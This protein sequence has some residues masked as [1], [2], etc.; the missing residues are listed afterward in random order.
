ML[1]PGDGGDGSGA[2]QLKILKKKR[3]HVKAQC[4]R[5]SSYLDGLDRQGIAIAELRQRLQKFNETWDSFNVTQSAI[6]DI[7]DDPENAEGHERERNLFEEKYFH[8]AS[9]LETLIDRKLAAQTP[10]LNQIPRE[11]REGTPATYATSA[12]DHLKLPRVNLPTFSGTFEQWIPFRNMFQSM[13]HNNA[14]LPD[15][16]KMQYLISALK[17][18]AFDVISSLEVADENYI[19]AWEMLKESYDDARSITQKHVKALF[20]IPV[21]GKENYSLIK[22]LLNSVFK[23]LKALKALK[24]PTEYWDDLIIYMVTSRL[25]QKT[26]RAWELTIKKGESPTLK[27]LTDFLTQYSKSLEASDRTSRSGVPSAAQ[28]KGS[29]TRSTAAHV[30]TTNNKCA[31]CAKE[32]HAIY[33]CESYLKLEIDKRIK[34]ARSRGLCLNCLKGTSHRAKQCS[35]STCRTCGKKHNTLLHL[36]QA[37]A[38]RAGSSL[39]DSNIANQEKVVATSVNHASFK[40]NKQ[41]LLATALVKVMDNKGKEVSCRALLDSGSQSCFITV[42]CAKALALKQSA[43][44]IPVCGLGEMSTQASNKVKIKLQSRINKFKAELD[45]LIIEQI[46]QTMPSGRIRAKEVSIPDGITLA[47]PEFCRSSKV[48]LLLGAEIFFDLMCVGRIKLSP[49]QPTWQKTLLGWIAS[50]SLVTATPSQ[51]GTIC[52]LA[53]N[54]QLNANLSRFWQIEHDERQVTR[55]P[56]ERKCERHFAETYRRD[57]EGKFIVSMPI[58]EEQLRRLGESRDLAIKRFKNIERKFERQPQLKQEYSK[59]MHEYLE[60]KHMKEIRK[61][62]SEWDI[63]PQYYLPHHCVIK[64]SSATTKLRVVFDASSKTTEGVSLNDILMVG[65]VLQ[66]DLFSILLRF[67]TFKYVITSDIAKMYR[68]I[69]L[70]DNQTPLQRIIWRDNPSEDIRT[71]ELLT[72]TYG[73]APAS[74]LATKVIHQL[75]DL[76]ENQF[77]K[78]AAIARRDFYMDDLITGANSMEEALVIRNEVAAMLRKGGFILRKWAANHPELLRDIPGHV[79]DNAIMELDKDG[80]AKTLGVK[81]N[82]S[83]DAF[84]YSIQIARPVSCTKRLMLSSI[85]QIFDPL[86]LLA[87]VI[88][89]AKLLIQE[90]WKLQMEWDESLPS[91]IFTKWLNY[92]ADIQYLN[93][94]GVQRQVIGEEPGAE[95]QLHGF[96]DASERAYGAC[97]YMRSV[98]RSKIQAH[99]LCAKSRVAPLKTVSIPRLEL[100]GAQLL[101]R[102]MSK[103]KA[104]LDIKISKVHYWTDSSVTL[105]WIKA[106]NKKLPV[107]VAHRVGEIQ[108]LTAVE[109]WNHVGTKE[110]PADLVSRSTTAKELCSTQLWWHGPTWLN[111]QSQIERQ[112]KL[113]VVEDQQPE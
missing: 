44:H 113:E 32:G 82:H 48:D 87:P 3:A 45:C 11:L 6:E 17:G 14:T 85:A 81:W 91:D 61:D 75:A 95:I 73:T 97:V 72:L 51:N 15:V 94:F 37:P 69:R 88:L 19:E 70:E 41:V 90:L 83:K 5:F 52:S 84:Q 28:E 20:E 71:Y 104:S 34:E 40:Q 23:H 63:Q 12:N 35:I 96:C 68:Q 31:Y 80:T 10:G 55:S 92:V 105:H 24:R 30:A 76:E 25:D 77:P 1:G 21:M 106:T 102:L 89:T 99:L 62:S 26:N 56:E 7:E 108:E 53:T 57:E 107:F 27:Q 67:R 79:T 101:A 58:E 86:G 103:I 2:A 49:T 65:P 60:L 74:F 59:F 36:E 66:Q 93:E 54:E 9:E 33:K 39:E 109:D 111:S 43:V 16:Q 100:C 8:I 112:L 13:I 46:T 64:E 110:N 38:S 4:T 22:Q 98:G 78:G 42:S 47:D 18:E 50:G 29:S